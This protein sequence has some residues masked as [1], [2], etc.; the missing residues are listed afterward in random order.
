MPVKATSSSSPVPIGS[1]TESV[2]Y[3]SKLI[4][5]ADSGVS[6]SIVNVILEPVS[7]TSPI[8]SCTP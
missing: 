3:G 1:A 5:A 6:P 7:V 4:V 2:P 8:V